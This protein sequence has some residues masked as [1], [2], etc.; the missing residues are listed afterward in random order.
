M[1]IYLEAFTNASLSQLQKILHGFQG[2]VISFYGAQLEKY[3]AFLSA[4][5]SDVRA[6]LASEAVTFSLTPQRLKANRRQGISL[7][8]HT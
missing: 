5:N 8:S 2:R 6:L 7:F 4:A 3:T 1:I